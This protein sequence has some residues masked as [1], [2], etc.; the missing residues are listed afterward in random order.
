MLL[1]FTAENFRSFKDRAEL[2]LVPS[3]VRRHP[4]HI[5]K[6]KNSTDISALKTA[7]IYGSNAS[8]K[9]NLI[10][11]MQHV[12]VMVNHGVRSGKKIP[13]DPYK[14]ESRPE[15][16]PS[17][18]EFEIKVGSNNYS[19][20]FSADNDSI[21]EEWLYKID[22]R[23]D[24]LIFNREQINGETK[25]QFGNI[26]YENEKDEQYLEFTS[27]GTPENRLF[28]NECKERNVTTQ[29]EYLTGI[30][31][32]IFWFEHILTII[33]PESK[34]AGLEITIHKDRESS[35]DI[36]NILKNYDTGIDSLELQQLDFK[37]DV[38]DVPEEIKQS[39]LDD[40]EDNS[41]VLLA[42][43]HNT[44]YLIRKPKEGDI[45]A[46]KLM[47]GHLKSNGDKV[48]FNIN[49]ESNGTQRLLDMAPGFLDASADEK[50]Y[51][52]DELNRSLHPDITTSIIK[53]F[54][55]NTAGK[56]SQI[57]VTTHETNLLDQDLV[58]K[59]EI[60]FVQKNTH[61]T[62]YSLEEY[63]PRF[64]KDVRR[65]YLAGRFGGLP[66][67]SNSRKLFKLN[68]NG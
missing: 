42:A 55:E 7:I 51:V 11:A 54:L 17:R 56:Q 5:I 15:K 3:K 28:L 31:E 40:L 63:Q 64:D 49:E 29:L 13:F 53:T 50:V 16:K 58:R 46:Y 45:E 37:S 12:Q 25:F 65:G 26:T 8:G 21:K 2:S 18:F 23:K 30:S 39:I 4:E 52:I 34:F 35:K 60:W 44:R 24:E 14:L 66:R 1:R 41:G 22:R 38:T 61:S 47:T 9:S 36:A 19:Y 43:P 33:F 32:V 20:G 57:I 27:K 62:L 59:D 6:A 10:K 48:L 67:L 68:S